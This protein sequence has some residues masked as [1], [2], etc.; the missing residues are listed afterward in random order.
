MSQIP[1]DFLIPQAMGNEEE[2][3]VYCNGQVVAFLEPFM[4]DDL[5]YAIGVHHQGRFYNNGF[6]AYQDGEHFE[7]ATPECKTP[8]SI[9]TYI[10]ATENLLVASVANYMQSLTVYEQNQH[11]VIRRRV[12]DNQGNSWGCHDNFSIKGTFAEK[13]M[14]DHSAEKAALIGHLA[15]RSFVTGAGNVAGN[16]FYF[17]QKARTVATLHK[18]NFESSLYRVDGR[19]EEYEK[20]LE[21]RNS[22]INISDWATRMRFSSLVL[23]LL[24]SRTEYKDELFTTHPSDAIDQMKRMNRIEINQDGS[25]EVSAEVKH[26]VDAQHRLAELSLRYFDTHGSKEEELRF[27]A[28]E[29][30]TF[31]D[32]MKSVMTHDQSSTILADRADWAAKL[33]FVI[34]DMTTNQQAEARSPYD[35]R[36]QHIDLEYD[37]IK[38]EK[39]DDQYVTISYGLGYRMRDKGILRN[40]VDKE[41]AEYAAKNAPDN[42]RAFT[43]SRLITEFNH[44]RPLVDWDKVWLAEG[45]NRHVYSLSDPASNKLSSNNLKTTKIRQRKKQSLA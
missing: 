4:P 28:E 39:S 32:D 31:C 8:D 21:I 26:A 10:R 45:V 12:I 17:A 37:R 15:T 29:L 25:I 14:D 11:A 20:R 2:T 19:A 43:R 5:L 30:Y 22:D 16:N 41:L 24:I 35:V 18:Y 23:A 7:I 34:R 13:L 27:A 33:Q 1:E 36:A 3:A 40:S 44:L 6:K 38:L 9:A 42:T